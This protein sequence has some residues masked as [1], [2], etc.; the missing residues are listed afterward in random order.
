MYLT[1]PQIH[2]LVYNVYKTHIIFTYFMLWNNSFVKW[3][4]YVTFLNEIIICCDL[5]SYFYILCVFNC[6]N[7]C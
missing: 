7:A 4:T 5:H 6:I 2:I 1:K 3:Y